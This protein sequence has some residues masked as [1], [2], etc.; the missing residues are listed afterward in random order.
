MHNWQDLSDRIN[1]PI[2]VDTCKIYPLLGTDAVH[3]NQHVIGQPLF[4]HNIGLAATHDKDLL[5]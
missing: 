1:R 2:T 4:P 5:Y 3:G